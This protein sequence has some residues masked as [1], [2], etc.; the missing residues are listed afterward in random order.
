[1][2]KRYSRER[3]RKGLDLRSD[4][5]LR[6]EWHLTREDCEA[7]I[8]TWGEATAQK[9]LVSAFA[10]AKDTKFKQ[11]KQL[12][13]LLLQKGVRRY[14]I[15]KAMHEKNNAKSVK[16]VLDMIND[17]I[18]AVRRWQEDTGDTLDIGE[19]G[20]GSCFPGRKYGISYLRWGLSSREADSLMQ[21]LAAGLRK[22]VGGKI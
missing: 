4:P 12:V 22:Q 8:K 21:R 16:A 10:A 15:A 11:K 5:K 1:V 7:L 3:K 14:T 18:A 2:R 19:V 9:I 6:V 20:S 13:E 17:A